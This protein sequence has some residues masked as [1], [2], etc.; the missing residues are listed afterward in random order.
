MIK[1]RIL[2]AFSASIFVFGIGITQQSLAVAP[3]VAAPA[4]AKVAAPVATQ[5]AKSVFMRLMIKGTPVVVQLIRNQAGK[6]I[7]GGLVTNPST[8]AVIATGVATTL[9]ITLMIEGAPVYIPLAKKSGKWI[10]TKSSK[11]IENTIETVNIVYEGGKQAIISSGKAIGHATEVAYDAGKWIAICH[12]GKT[13]GA[14]GGA[15]AGGATGSVVGASVATALCLGS[16]GL[17]AATFGSSLLLAAGFC[18]SA[19]ATGTA[20]G[21]GVGAVG[22]GVAGGMLGKLADGE[23]C[24]IKENE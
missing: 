4:A 14:V 18:S 16:I 11:A 10:V 3:A 13:I 6:L 8:G 22:G 9:V 5:A 23:E 15:V 24:I 7:L 20:V 1:K 12:K 19:I 2:S 21:I 17:S